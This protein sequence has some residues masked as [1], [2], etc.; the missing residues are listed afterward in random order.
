[1]EGQQRQ[2]AGR[3]HERDSSVTVH[4]LAPLQFP[5]SQSSGSTLHSA[6]NT[7]TPPRD[8]DQPAAP[9]TPAPAAPKPPRAAGTNE[10]L[11]S[12]NNE[13]EQTNVAQ[14]RVLH[15]LPPERFGDRGLP[16]THA[17]PGRGVRH[18][19]CHRHA[20]RGGGLP[21]PPPNG[22]LGQSD[23]CA[24]SHPSSSSEHH[25]SLQG[26]TAA[27]AEWRSNMGA[28]QPQ[29]VVARVGRAH[30]ELDVVTAM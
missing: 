16:P 5:R 23:R 28:G 6:W 25:R 20:D 7:P 9:E 14:P 12:G 30:E 15:D 19:G 17:A 3:T 10:R 2:A 18:H 22:R 13:A 21:S 29:G 11:P 24:S 4:P 8:H 26:F 1:M 27:R